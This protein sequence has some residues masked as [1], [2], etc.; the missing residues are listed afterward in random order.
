[1]AHAADL[2]PCT[3]P[4][5]Q[6][7]AHLGSV[8]R[9]ADFVVPNLRGMGQPGHF[10]FLASQRRCAVPAVRHRPA[11]HGQSGPVGAGSPGHASAA[12]GKRTP[13]T[14]CPSR[15]H[16][17]QSSP[18]SRSGWR[19]PPPAPPWPAPPGWPAWTAAR[20]GQAAQVWSLS[21]AGQGRQGATAHAERRMLRARSTACHDL[22]LAAPPSWVTST[23]TCS[24]SEPPP[25]PID[26][27]SCYNPQRQILHCLPTCSWSEPP[28]PI[29]SS[30]AAASGAAPP[31]RLVWYWQ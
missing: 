28:P 11:Q 8:Q 30:S 18:R 15:P 3:V 2:P 5:L 10:S 19:W 1:M 17:P 4:P 12:G 31:L 29:D 27:S 14:A 6:Q 23:P 22:P 20:A 7:Q 13:Q 25:L 24:W 9:H 26:S 21:T 16:P